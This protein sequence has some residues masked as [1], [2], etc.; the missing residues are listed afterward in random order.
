MTKFKPLWIAGLI[1]VVG[2]AWCAC[3]TTEQPPPPRPTPSPVTIIGKDGKEMVLVPAGEFLMGTSDAQLEAFLQTH[4]GWK[5]EWLSIE[6]PQ[7]QVFLDAFYIDETE[8][9]NAEYRRFVV[10]SGHETPRHWENGQVPAGQDDYPVVN[11]RL[12][13][14][15]AYA[16]WAG[17]RLPTEAEWEKAARGTDGRIYPWGDSWDP[18]KANALGSGR[19]GPAPVGSYGP[20]SAS[21]YGALD[22]AG[23]AWEWCADWYAGDYYVGSPLRNPQGPQ[24]VTGTHPVVRGGSWFD[25]PEYARCAFRYGLNPRRLLPNQGFRCVQ[26]P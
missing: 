26:E 13:D 9:T 19:S 23:N 21:P 4:P 14:A 16:A 5:P 22:L 15:Q 10:A 18:E 8:V 24:A 17:K 6:Q 1:V 25:P 3:V 12:E 20:A 11:I 2:S 7:H